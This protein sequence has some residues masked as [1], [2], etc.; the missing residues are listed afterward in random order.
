MRIISQDNDLDLPYENIAIS[1]GFRGDK[2]EFYIFD[3]CKNF[4]FFSVNP[5]GIETNNV[6]S[7][8]ERI[9]G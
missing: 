6:I 9:Y 8:T 3:Y 4:E 7:L 1:R 2:K 5:K